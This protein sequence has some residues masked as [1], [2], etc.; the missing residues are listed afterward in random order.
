MQEHTT[1]QKTN[2]SQNPKQIPM[3]QRLNRTKTTKFDNRRDIHRKDVLVTG[4][5]TDH[6]TSDHLHRESPM[7]V[8]FQ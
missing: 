8:L 5:N 1:S 3:P 4:A 7:L 2:Q 6:L